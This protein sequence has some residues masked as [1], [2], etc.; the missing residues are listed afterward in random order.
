MRHH[1]S[2]NKSTSEDTQWRGFTDDHCGWESGGTRIIEQ[3]KVDKATKSIHQAGSTSWWARDSNTRKSEKVELSGRHYKW[4]LPKYWYLCGIVDCAN[5]AIALEPN[6][7][8]SS[9][10]SGLYVV[11]AILGWCVAWPIS[12]TNKNGN[13][14]SCNRVSVKEAGSQNLGKHH[15]FVI[16][17]VKDIGIKDVLNKI[18]H[19]DFSE[20]LIQPRK[21]DKLL[22]LSDELS[23]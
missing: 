2:R 8:I 17:E 4:N 9:R 12:C 1:W 14:V 7:V 23:W 20:L 3:T 6:E 19:A 21:F 10:E 13:K 16:N 15:F 11:K 22:N 5:C 18:Y